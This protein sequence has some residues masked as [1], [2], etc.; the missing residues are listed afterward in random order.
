MTNRNKAESFELSCKTKLLTFL[1]LLICLGLIGCGSGA[2]N[3]GRANKTTAPTGITYSTNPAVYA[4]DVSIMEIIP[5]VRG[6]KA[7]A[8][9]VSPPLPNGLNLDPATGIISGTP[10]TTLAKTS[11]LVTAK[12]AAGSVSVTL[13][14]STDQAVYPLVKLAI[15]RESYG[16]W[17]RS[18]FH[19]VVD[20]PFTRGQGYEQLWDEIN[21]KV[22]GLYDWSQLDA[23]L[24]FAEEQNEK[25][26]IQIT[27][28][29][30][31]GGSTMPTW[32]FEENGGG[33]PKASGD[34]Y[35]YGFYL[36]PEFKVYYSE[37]VQ[38]LAGHVRHD[39]APNLQARIN[40]VRV[41][42]GAT[43]D[44]APYENP[45]V[46]AG[47]PFEIS[48]TQWQ[49]HRLWAFEVYRA[50]F[51]DGAGPVIPLLFQDIENTNYPVEWKWVIDN[52]KG[53]FGAKYGGAVRGHNL[54]GSQDVSDSFRS[55]AVDPPAGINMFSRNEMDG[56]WSRPF[57]QL[58][59]RLNMYWTAVEQLHAGLNIWDITGNCLENTY[60]D[61]FVF[62]FEFFNKWAAELDPVTAGGGFIIF[63]EGLDTSDINKFPE[64]TFGL[65][66]KNNKE[67]Y[68]AITNAYSGQG[69]QMDDLDA[70]IQG[71]V[72]QRIIQKGYNDAGWR[73][74]PGNYERFIRQITPEATSKGMWRLNGPLTSTSNP[75]DRFARRFDHASGM[76]VM[77]F[78][79]HDKLLQSQGQPV[80]ISVDYL[81]RG[82]GQFSLKYDAIG[83]NK[84]TAFTVTKTNTN[85]WKTHSIVLTDW[86]FG[87]HGPNGADFMLVNM[88]SDDDILHGVEIIK[89]AD[90]SMG[91]V[92]QG[93]VTARNNSSA[94]TAVPSSMMEGQILELKVIPAANWQFTGW[95]GALTGTNTRPFLFP[96][97]DTRLTA[98]FSYVGS[99]S[100]PAPLFSL[101][102]ISQADARQGFSYQAN[103]AGFAS[104]PSNRP[105]TFS[106]ISGPVWLNIAANGTLSGIPNSADVGLNHW[107]IQVANSGG[108]TDDAT[109]V[110]RVSQ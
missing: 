25:I 11:Y 90:V 57:F 92:G 7:T 49:A 71:N 16:V 81:D 4:K 85:I 74:V 97:R 76:D 43:G 20:Y 98:H 1:L 104:D 60:V 6:G 28:V 84:K 5:T 88:D 32:I 48:D 24:Q 14:L 19:L 54:T 18:G 103:I 56:T 109:L 65:A 47:T 108:G 15:A 27:T 80:Q 70:A 87:N 2:F 45:G 40:S 72:R 36:D 26:N 8:F 105:I 33:V 64:S 63:H 102:P 31:A 12:N 41:D 86:V 22:R 9:T 37:M 82:T 55:V 93:T 23:Q 35:T 73:I 59:V 62:A 68:S 38:A 50:A 107:S 3:G 30:G 89:L 53:G 91:T 66:K 21:G 10:T 51:Q 95:S 46:F 44:E 94:Y 110:I 79:I 29:G 106:K 58:N 34:I 17:D 52:V 78:D 101:D 77:Y 13:T 42:T 83:N 69:A 75:Y 99:V 96:S 39:I 67:R 100:Q 61:N